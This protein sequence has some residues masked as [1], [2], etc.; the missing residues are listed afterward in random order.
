M[1]LVGIGKAVPTTALDVSGTVTADA[2]AGDGSALT[3]ITAGVAGADTQLQFN[4]GGVLA[5]DSALNW[6]KT[7]DRLGV[8]TASPNATV[9]VSGTIKLAGTG[10]D[11]CGGTNHGTLRFVSGRLQMCVTD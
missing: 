1:P 5:G 2:F 9:D 11:A 4:D 7:N 10:A 3:G 8:A 6:D